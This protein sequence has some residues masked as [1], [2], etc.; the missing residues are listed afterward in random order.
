MADINVFFWFDVEDYITPESDDALQGILNIFETNRV[1]GTFK[2]VGEK[3]RALKRRERWDIIDALRRQDIGYHTDFHSVHP[4][5]AEYLKDL[6]WVQGVN[7]F[8]RR[9]EAGFEELLDTFKTVSCYGQPGSSWAPHVYPALQSWGIPV[10]LD[11]ARHICLNDEPFWYCG[12]LNIINLKSNSTRFEHKL[13]ERGLSEAKKEFDAIYRRLMEAG[14]GAI[15]IYYHPCE[16][17]T[18]E[19]WDAVNFAKGD[20]PDRSHWVKPRVK[21]REE[22]EKELALLSMYVQHIASKRNVRCVTAKDAHEAYSDPMRNRSYSVEDILAIAEAIRPEITYLKFDQGYLT[23]AE[24]LY[25][26]LRLLR[27]VDPF[28]MAGNRS[29]RRSLGTFEAR[30]THP[31]YG[32]IKRTPSNPVPC[33]LSD[34]LSACAEACVFMESECRTP[35]AVPVGAS[36]WN[37][38]EFLLAVCSLLK[39]VSDGRKANDPTSSAIIE[40]LIRPQKA[41]LRLENQVTDEGVWDW[42]IFPENFSAPSVIELARLQTWSLKPAR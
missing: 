42:V 40:G 2:I 41:T 36:L 37:P 1:R 34:F 18:Y 24:V 5:P 10:Y 33:S 8:K 15:S 35:N 20:N 25:L 17:A 19:F 16:F 12:I 31:L 23:P 22:M 11:Y 39:S 29:W 7:E 4:T 13:G 21:P 32:P 28:D 26:T 30:L 27:A 38:E 14:G 9:E 3:L 6:D